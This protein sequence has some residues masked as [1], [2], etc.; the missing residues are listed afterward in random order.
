MECV[1]H[2]AYG[3]APTQLGEHERGV[4][5]RFPTAVARPRY[6]CWPTA[7]WKQPRP[8]WWDTR[9][10][11]PWNIMEP[12]IVPRSRNL[13]TLLGPKSLLGSTISIKIS[14]RAAPREPSS[15]H[16]DHPA[17]AEAVG[18]YAEALGEERLAE[19]H[20]HLA[21]GGERR[22]HAVGLG[23]VLGVDREREAL[24][25][26]LALCAAVGRHHRLAVDAQA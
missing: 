11:K 1:R 20:P 17:D 15:L 5:R 25:F 26:R 8:P 23:F 3:L 4:D 9:P 7:A 13:L 14:L 2:V 10:Q 24:E 22:E 18:D 19:R 21:A 16:D 12:T 6:S